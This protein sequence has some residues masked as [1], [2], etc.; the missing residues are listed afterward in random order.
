MTLIAALNAHALKTTTDAWATAAFMTT[1]GIF[2]VTTW[3][4]L[5]AERSTR[6]GRLAFALAGCGYLVIS[7]LLH[8]PVPVGFTD[9]WL[10][11]HCLLAIAGGGAAAWV[12]RV[13][14]SGL[15]PAMSTEQNP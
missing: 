7:R 15:E 10:V 4:S 6:R 11:A 12:I 14:N 3:T 2:V 1:V 5:E 13:S 9:V 8:Q